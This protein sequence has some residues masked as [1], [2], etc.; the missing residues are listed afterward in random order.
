ML[1]RVVATPCE[2]GLIDWI[3]RVSY[4]RTVGKGLGT[5]CFRNWLRE[6]AS[7]RRKT[8]FHIWTDFL[9]QLLAKVVCMLVYRSL[10]VELSRLDSVFIKWR[11]FS[12]SL[13]VQVIVVFTVL[14]LV[15]SHQLTISLQLLSLIDAGNC[16][17]I[18][19]VPSILLRFKRLL[20]FKLLLSSF[21]DLID[22]LLSW[23]YD[24]HE[25]FFLQLLLHLSLKAL[26]ITNDLLLLI[27][28]LPLPFR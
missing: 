10:R 6:F 3:D 21:V 18:A 26:S 12:W 2:T 17:I 8:T 22:V 27:L 7:M 9:G 19:L 24:L 25:V 23:S 4:V 1:R 20:L 5:Y 11:V 28:K 16:W 13:L 14:L 15:T